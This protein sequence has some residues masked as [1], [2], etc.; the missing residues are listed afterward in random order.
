MKL[1]F[2]HP[3]DISFDD[4]RRIQAQ[5]RKQ[6]VIRNTLSI[7]DIRTIAA[8]D[9]SYSQKSNLLFAVVVLVSF[10]ALALKSVY[11]HE[12]QV[13]FP[14]VPG[15]LSFREIPVLTEIFSEM[16]EYFDVLLC[17]G[18]GFAH[19]RRF[20]LACHLGVLLKKPSLGCAKTRLLGNYAEPGPEKGNYSFLTD[21]DEKI[22]IVLRT[23]PGV[24]PL[25]VSPGHLVNFEDCRSIILAATAKYRIAEPLRLAHQH[26]N[27]M[28]KLKM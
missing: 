16:D 8:A 24:K 18:Q 12:K 6:V 28:R 9:V 19:P 11:T 3:W 25:F 10:P 4:A 20:G 26:V 27:R 23:R 14:Y 5:L 15:F 21:K 22:G 13:N 2:S 1:Y 17:D 7:S